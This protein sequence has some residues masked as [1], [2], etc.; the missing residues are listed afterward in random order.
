[1]TVI[2][3]F[4]ARYS[5]NW[6]FVVKLF[7]HT[8]CK[9]T[10]YTVNT[11]GLNTVIYPIHFFQMF[12]TKRFRTG[13]SRKISYNPRM[14]FMLLVASQRSWGERVRSSMSVESFLNTDTLRTR[15]GRMKTKIEA[16]PPPS[17]GGYRTTVNN[18]RK[19]KNRYTL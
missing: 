10:F 1:M 17:L 8:N 13:T 12:F 2:F 3:E 14:K 6:P 15:H 7:T 11:F 4:K 16:S 18:R 5:Q 19:T 9:Y